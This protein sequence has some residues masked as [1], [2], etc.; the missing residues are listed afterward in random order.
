MGL[1]NML[2]FLSYFEVYLV[3]F[4]TNS[5]FCCSYYPILQFAVYGPAGLKL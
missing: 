4:S 1:P 3:F 2:P 5:V